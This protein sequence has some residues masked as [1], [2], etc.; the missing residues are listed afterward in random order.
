MPTVAQN[1]VEAFKKQPGVTRHGEEGEEDIGAKV[2]KSFG[3]VHLNREETK[4]AQK[5]LV[6]NQITRAF[7]VWRFPDGSLA[8]TCTSSFHLRAD[9]ELTL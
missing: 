7:G 5:W 3:G 1:A 2:A 8:Y 6:K 4:Q 9:L